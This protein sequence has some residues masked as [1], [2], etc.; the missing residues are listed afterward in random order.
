MSESPACAHFE[1]GSD[2]T[3]RSDDSL[4]DPFNWTVAGH[5][6]KLAL[7]VKMFD[8]RRCQQVMLLKAPD[9]VLSR[10]IWALDQATVVPVTGS[11]YFR[12]ILVNIESRLAE[13]TVSTPG[14]PAE[15]LSAAQDDVDGKYGSLS[16]L[17]PNS[18]AQPDGLLQGAGKSVQN[19]AASCVR[20]EEPN[21]NQLF[22]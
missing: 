13:R 12:K 11:V 2:E 1:L 22:D 3:A 5:L 18:L 6:D 9:K 20:F 7:S 17:H 21:F 14:D 10:V 15:E 4:R 8:D 19:V 16:A